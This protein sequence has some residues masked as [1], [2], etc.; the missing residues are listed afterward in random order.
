MN[1]ADMYFWYDGG[2][3]GDYTAGGIQIPKEYYYEY[4]DSEGNWQPLENVSSYEI[5]MDKF[6]T[7]T[8]DEVTTTSI[9]VTMV[10]QE[11]D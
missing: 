2:K 6:N 4:L 8:F 1:K 7:V 11:A 5:A 3:R 10:K 9:R